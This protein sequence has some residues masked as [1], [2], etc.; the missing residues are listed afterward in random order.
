MKEAKQ[1]AIGIDAIRPF[2]SQ[3]L[4]QH[5]QRLY[6]DLSFGQLRRCQLDI[7]TASADGGFPDASRPGDRVL[8]IGLRAG[9]ENRLLVLA[10]MTDA[11]EKKLLADF[12]AALAEIELEDVVP[13]DHV[14]IDL[15]ERRIKIG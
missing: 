1:T 8:A 10:E 6:R 15:G 11:A 4:L 14:G 2:E 7:E 5:R 13:L 12:N 3:F 9:G